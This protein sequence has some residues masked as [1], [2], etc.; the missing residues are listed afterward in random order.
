MSS[1]VYHWLWYCPHTCGVVLAFQSSPSIGGKLH[2]LL[3][4]L[5][6]MSWLYSSHA[7][8]ICSHR[9]LRH[10]C[11][12]F[13]QPK[14]TASLGS[15]SAGDWILF[16][17]IMVSCLG[18]L[19]SLL[20]TS[21]PSLLSLLNLEVAF[22]HFASLPTGSSVSCRGSSKSNTFQA[23]TDGALRYLTD[24]LSSRILSS[25][26]IVLIPVHVCSQ[27]L[28]LVHWVCQALLW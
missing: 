15:W 6:R 8:F 4:P 28:S 22:S 24:I 16:G 10:L 18:F 14:S 7:F 12:A 23:S 27:G 11:L 25:Y 20:L 13:S 21:C 1:L 3:S 19:N 5:L 17:R 9:H 26:S 2:S